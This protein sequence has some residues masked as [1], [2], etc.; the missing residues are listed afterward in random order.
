[1]MADPPRCSAQRAA[2]GRDVKAR[3]LV[4]FSLPFR[5][6]FVPTLILFVSIYHRDF[7]S[8]PELLPCQCARSVIFFIFSIINV[9]FFSRAVRKF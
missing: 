3:A 5:G 6:V 9:D 4:G 2:I 7:F 8:I 1:M